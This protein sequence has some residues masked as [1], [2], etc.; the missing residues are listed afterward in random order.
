MALRAL[1][2]PVS[3]TPVG[4]TGTTNTIPRWT[5]PSTLGD[6]LLTQSGAT[7]TQ[8]G[9][10]NGAV[11]FNV[12]N[13]N[14]GASAYSAVEIDSA[15]ASWRLK[16]IR[17]AGMFAIE[18]NG[19]VAVQIDN[20]LNVG[21]GTASPLGYANYVA[22]NIGD[23]N[24]AKTGLLKFRS[25]YNAG[26]GAELYQATD[27]RV[28]LNADGTG[29]TSAIFDPTNRILNIA[30][31]SGWGLKLNAT[32]GNPDTQTLD[33]Y[34]ENTFTPTIQGGTTAGVG[35]YTSQVGTFTII[36]R[37]LFFNVEIVWSAHTG[38]G[39]V[40][41]AGLPVA[42]AQLATFGL[43]SNYTAAGYLRMSA[44]N[45]YAQI[46]TINVPATGNYRV[47]GCYFIA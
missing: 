25:T 30:P 38:T 35:T 11:A 22:L 24:A 34:K 47:S 4:G 45:T 23:N 37:C 6:S 18:R 3:G 42:A 32:P 19:V 7:I 9:S 39:L 12:T 21:I 33:A 41:L 8:T 43:D 46:N 29:A 44:G 28:I 40:Q 1:Q 36:G 26:N 14:T 16:S 13:Q 17:T 20:V 31:A 15:G 5:G 10:V 2:G 27:G